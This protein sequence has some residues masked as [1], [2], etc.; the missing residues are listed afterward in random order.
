VFNGGK[1]DVFQVRLGC[2]KPFTR[3][4]FAE[5]MDEWFTGHQLV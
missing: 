5:N 3:I 4:S 2:L 1:E